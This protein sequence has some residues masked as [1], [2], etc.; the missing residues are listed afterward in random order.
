MR[1]PKEMYDLRDSYKARVEQSADYR[2][3]QALDTAIAQIEEPQHLRLHSTTPDK[4]KRI[5]Q[6][7]RSYADVAYDA[8]CERQK[9][10]RTP[11]I[12]A[13]AVDEGIADPDTKPT[14]LASSL[15]RD[16]RLVSIQFEGERH[17]W[18]AGTPPPG[19]LGFDE[20]EGQSV[21]GQPSAS[22]ANQGG[23]EMPPP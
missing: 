17:W 18:L 14:N 3:W 8:I 22:N 19:G 4:P 1:A 7:R 21:E 20:A 11:D 9:P 13:C 2:A 6:G 10:M 23:S 15:S 12:L 5:R 16:D